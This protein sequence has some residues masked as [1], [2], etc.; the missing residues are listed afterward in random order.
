MMH[1][2]CEYAII[3]IVNTCFELYQRCFY[4]YSYPGLVMIL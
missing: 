2:D 1:D 3:Y 4:W